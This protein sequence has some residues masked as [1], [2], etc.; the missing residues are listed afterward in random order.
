MLTETLA[1]GVSTEVID[2]ATLKPLDMPTILTLVA[3]AVSVVCS[4]VGNSVSL[5]QSSSST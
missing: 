5:L 2:V 3:P 1:A 4:R